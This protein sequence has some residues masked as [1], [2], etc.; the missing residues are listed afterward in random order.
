MS[1]VFREQPA[2]HHLPIL[3]LLAMRSWT[4]YELTNQVQRSLH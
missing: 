2:D 4:T 3:G 1:D